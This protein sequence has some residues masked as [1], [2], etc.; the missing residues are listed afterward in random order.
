MTAVLLMDRLGTGGTENQMAL[1]CR[2]WPRQELPLAILCLDHEHEPEVRI[3]P[4]VEIRFTGRAWKYDP[5][6]FFRVARQLRGLDCDVVLA[7]HRFSG[8]VGKLV[9]GATLGIPTIVEIRGRTRPGG[10]RQFLYD[11]VDENLLWLADAVVVNSAFV[12]QSLR[13]KRRVANRIHLIPNGLEASGGADSRIA[14]NLRHE[15]RIP[16]ESI[17]CM[18]VGRLAPIKNQ[19]AAIDAVSPLRVEGHDVYLVLLG[20]GPDRPRLE[21]HVRDRQLTEF[22]RFLG[23]VPETTEYVAQADVYLHPSRWENCS[24][25]ILEAM[26]AG[27]P[28]VALDVGGNAETLEQG[29]AGVL[30]PD[31]SPT[32]LAR[33]TADLLGEETRRASMTDRA[34]RRVAEN[35]SVEGMVQAHLALVR[36]VIANSAPAR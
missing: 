21:R 3:P 16:S 10:Q 32:A 22:V 5:R 35:Y 19:K 36:S 24:N 18:T 4:D 30:V 6:M 8:L 9:G 7:P 29:A 31:S 23:S 27:V 14:R 17:I 34:R 11:V 26:A 15:L 28:V 20:D 13:R 25:A 33:A 2:H 12:A 1:L